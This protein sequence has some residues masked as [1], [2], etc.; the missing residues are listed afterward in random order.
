MTTRIG[1]RSPLKAGH[2]PPETKPASIHGSLND[3]PA[4]L[5]WLINDLRQR[6]AGRTALV[7]NGDFIDFLAQAPALAFDV[8]NRGEAGAKASD[9]A[10]E[11]VAKAGADSFSA[12]NA[13][14][15]RLVYERGRAGRRS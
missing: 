13:S 2:R 15:C 12:P 1:G 3:E 11:L 10:R 8:S 9:Y 6:R 4:E 5:A 14:L 7:I